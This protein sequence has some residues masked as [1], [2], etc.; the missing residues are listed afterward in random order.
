MASPP[1][2]VDRS[3]IKKVGVERRVSLS[4]GKGQSYGD[5]TVWVFKSPVRYVLNVL[6][7]VLESLLS[8]SAGQFEGACFLG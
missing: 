1:V 2:E 5:S 6:I 7:I 4:L 8:Q 3:N